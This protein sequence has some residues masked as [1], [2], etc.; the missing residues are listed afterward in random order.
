MV[1]HGVPQIMFIVLERE[2]KSGYVAAPCCTHP[3]T[4]LGKDT[5]RTGVMTHLQR[6]HGQ[7]SEL[8]DF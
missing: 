6:I 5:H 7:F 3:S 8:F 1:H 2:E 4:G